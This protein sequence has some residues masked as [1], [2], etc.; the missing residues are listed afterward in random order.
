MA[1]YNSRTKRRIYEKPTGIVRI[2]DQETK[3]DGEISNQR[4]WPGFGFNVKF[5]GF[6]LLGFHKLFWATF[7]VISRNESKHANFL[8]NKLAKGI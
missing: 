1:Y 7:Y 4:L 8:Q 2:C 3:E 5:V 6:Q